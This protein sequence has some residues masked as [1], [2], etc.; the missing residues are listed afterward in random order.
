MKA[1]PLVKNYK[2]L[3]PKERF[4]LILAASGRGDEAERDRLV[5]AGDRIHLSMQDHA[6]YAD[7]FNELA[8][9]IM[10]AV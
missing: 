9:L 10:V 2:S 5:R 6:P 8:M 1:P 3:T 4:Q 7:A